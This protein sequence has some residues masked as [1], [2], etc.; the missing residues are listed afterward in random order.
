[1]VSGSKDGKVCLWSL[2]NYN[3]LNTITICSSVQMLD[4]STD[5]IWLVACCKDSKVYIK[6]VATGTD[7]HT[8]ILGEHKAKVSIQR[9]PFIFCQIEKVLYLNL[10]CLNFAAI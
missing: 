7:V 6:T 1:M 10:Y 2:N 4:V 3:L 9:T 8:I 5:S